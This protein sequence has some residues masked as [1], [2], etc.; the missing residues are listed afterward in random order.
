MWASERRKGRE[1]REQTEPI[2]ENKVAKVTLVAWRAG[3]VQPKS[4]IYIYGA[5]QRPPHF[6]G[7]VLGGGAPMHRVA[8]EGHSRLTRWLVRHQHEGVGFLQQLDRSA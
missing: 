1:T 2:T 3:G 6:K 7:C 4:T 8:V 5:F